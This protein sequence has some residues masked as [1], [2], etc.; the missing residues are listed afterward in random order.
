MEL[1]CPG[2][3]KLTAAPECPRCGS[4]LALLF[5]IRE[6][7]AEDLAQAALLLRQRQPASAYAFANRSWEKIHSA[8][9]AKLAFLASLGTGDFASA[10]FWHAQA[11][12]EL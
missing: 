5:A 3:A 8:E 9:A 7:A 4:D 11:Q 6:T 1:K 2:C 12:N 10:S